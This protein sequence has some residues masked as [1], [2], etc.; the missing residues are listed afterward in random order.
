MTFFSVFG[1]FDSELGSLIRRTSLQIGVT[2]EA[3]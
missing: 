3:R 2:D 1:E